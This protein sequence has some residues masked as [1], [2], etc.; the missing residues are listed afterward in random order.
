MTGIPSVTAPT[1]WQ[2]GHVTDPATFA[3]CICR[4]RKNLGPPGADPELEPDRRPGG[5]PD[6][7][8]L[9]QP[10]AALSGP[11]YDKPVW[12]CSVRAAPEDRTLSDGEWA[13]VAAGIMHRTGLAPLGD[14]LG[15]RWVAVRH[16]PDHIHIVATLARQDAIKPSTWNDFYRVREACQ[17]AERRFGL[18]STAPADR[19][20]A[21][22]ATRAETEQAARRRWR[23]TPRAAL[24]REV[25]TAAAGAGLPGL[26]PRLRTRLRASIAV[27]SVS[28]RVPRY[29]CVVTMLEWPSR[30]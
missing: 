8:R 6:L 27:S 5:S 1:R 19:I 10:L 9:A 13:Q 11:G 16:A 22:R 3:C 30:P 23:E 18:R 29:F 15:V 28:S 17:D 20:A 21:R 12:H 26:L 24:R 25:C 4:V 2:L 14:E 7:R